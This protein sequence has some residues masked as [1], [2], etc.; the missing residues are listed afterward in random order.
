MLLL[1]YIG[2]Y[3]VG[4]LIG[5]GAKIVL[6]VQVRRPGIRQAAGLV[7]LAFVLWGAMSVTHTPF[8]DVILPLVWAGTGLLAG[9]GSRELHT[10]S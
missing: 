7:I 8:T 10:A 2:L 6:D 4:M 3:V 1:F 9:L 5:L